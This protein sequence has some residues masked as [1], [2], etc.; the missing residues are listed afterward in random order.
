M[1]HLGSDVNPSVTGGALRRFY[2][3][4]AFELGI[5]AR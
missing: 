3:L 1:G 2:V 4:E 5:N